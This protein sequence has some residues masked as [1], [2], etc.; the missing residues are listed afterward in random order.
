MGGL[1]NFFV[2]GAL[3]D[4]SETVR[5]QML[6][7]SLQ[8]VNLYGQV[9]RHFTYNAKYFEMYFFR[10]NIYK[11]QMIFLFNNSDWR[12]RWIICRTIHIIFVDDT[13]KMEA[14]CWMRNSCYLRVVWIQSII[15]SLIGPVANPNLTLYF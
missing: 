2:P 5:K 1:F 7:A 4:R 9:S 14:H 8:Y 15:L 11:K 12:K 10:R 6:E 3:G 13:L